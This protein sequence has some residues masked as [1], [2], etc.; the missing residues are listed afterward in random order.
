M[1]A[2]GGRAI[3]LQIANPAVGLGVAEH[4]DF[5]A[6]PTARL[7]NTLAYIY[8]VVYGTAAQRAAAVAAVGQAHAPVR[9]SA[10]GDDLAYSAF[11]PRLQLWVAA[12]LYDS[13][14]DMHQ[15][16]DGALD[17]ASAEL[18]YREYAVLGTAL[19][20]PPELWP[21]DLQAF[22][23]YF[24]EQLTLLHT[25]DQ[26]R[27]VA[28]ALLHPTVGPIWLKAAMPVAGLVTAGLLPAPVRESFGL[29][30]SATRQRRFDRLM[31]ITRVVYPRLPRALRHLP[32]HRLLASRPAAG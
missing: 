6:R 30:W 1:I 15:R 14:V 20:L 27:A 26:T 8:A 2:A 5:T 19:Q 29:P 32:R 3:L 24:A 25:D 17:A 9:S 7:A 22:D 13:A 31:L 11:D 21:A 10:G 16:I 28:A 12:T 4:S 23:V 18:V